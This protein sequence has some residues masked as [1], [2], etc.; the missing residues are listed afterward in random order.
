MALLWSSCTHGL[1]WQLAPTFFA[2]FLLIGA[3]L[4]A[5][6]EGAADYAK[7]SCREKQILLLASALFITTLFLDFAA[8]IVILLA[9]KGPSAVGTCYVDLRDEKRNEIFDSR[10]GGRRELP[11]QIWY[12][13]DATGSGAAIAPF[14]RESNVLDPFISAPH[15]AIAASH[16]HLIESHSLLNAKIAGDKNNT[17]Y[18]LLIFSHGI[19]GGRI[20]NTSLAESLA[21]NGYIVVGI[22][23][24]YDAAMAIFADKTI[25]S[26]L[27]SSK[28]SSISLVDNR[29]MDVRRDDVSFVLDQFEK[30]PSQISESLKAKADLERVGVYGHSLGGQAAMLACAADKRFAAGLSLD[31]FSTTAAPFSQP[32]MIVQADRPKAPVGVEK[33]DEGPNHLRL[34][35]KGAG[36][37]NF[38]DLPLVTPLHWILGMSGP[39]EVKRADTIVNKYCLAFFDRYLKRTESPLLNA[40]TPLF[41][42]MQFAG[43]R[44]KQ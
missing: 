12:P 7:A 34:T 6:T 24:P 9:P 11:V 23:H 37:A 25:T 35:L 30:A 32:F 41:P 36:H 42:E 16:L 28:L 5:K 31:G 33:F 29:A 15:L 13:A 19:L 21:S 20:Q 2:L 14:M 39:I 1:R 38:T 8:P 17:R 10:E 43:P 3:V 4:Y 26:L 22:D 27:V 44:K 40:P 18:P